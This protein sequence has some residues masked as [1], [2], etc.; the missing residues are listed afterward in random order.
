[1]Q[2]DADRIIQRYPRLCYSVTTNPMGSIETARYI[3]PTALSFT[4]TVSFFNMLTKDMWYECNVHSGCC[5]GNI[6]PDHNNLLKKIVLVKSMEH[7]VK[8]KWKTRIN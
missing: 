7:V 6:N 4:Y 1:M 5:M 3:I 8:C 2:T